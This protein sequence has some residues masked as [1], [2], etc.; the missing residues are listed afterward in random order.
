MLQE[1]L[2]DEDA[3]DISMT[4]SLRANSNRATSSA[5]ATKNTGLMPP[6]P[7]VNPEPIFNTRTVSEEISGYR[8]YGQNRVSSND[9]APKPQ[10][11]NSVP[12]GIN[13]L[14]ELQLSNTEKLV[15][16]EP[17]RQEHTPAGLNELT[18]SKERKSATAKGG[19]KVS[20]EIEAMLIAFQP[21]PFF[22]EE[23][24]VIF[25]KLRMRVAELFMQ[26]ILYQSESFITLALAAMSNSYLLGELADA[27]ADRGTGDNAK[28]HAYFKTAAAFFTP[29][30]DEKAHPLP[31][32]NHDAFERYLPPPPNST[33]NGSKFNAS[34]NSLN[35]LGSFGSANSSQGS[36]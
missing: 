21:P 22:T 10:K 12:M 1:A 24:I 30:N 18:G 8:Q 13:N 15:A 36:R 23:M 5:S 3:H 11:P 7:P 17:R 2:I 19:K 31:Q 28:L 32:Y 4:N 14:H 6:P 27:I 25:E 9:W 16:I 26:G 20:L 35:S 33:L 34:N 29:T